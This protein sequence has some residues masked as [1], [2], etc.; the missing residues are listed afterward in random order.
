MNRELVNFMATESTPKRESENFREIN[1]KDTYIYNIRRTDN[2]L[3]FNIKITG[4]YEKNISDLFIPAKFYQ[5]NYVE[6]PRKGNIVI[7]KSKLV[8]YFLIYP[9]A[10]LSLALIITTIFRY[11]PVLERLFTFPAF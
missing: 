7:S 11:L 4:D 10:I 6:A 2:G 5:Q 1:L 3:Y 8:E 9:G